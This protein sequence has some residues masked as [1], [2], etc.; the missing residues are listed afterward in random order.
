MKANMKTTEQ[1]VAPG[2]LH[3]CRL[4]RASLIVAVDGPLRIQY[5]DESLTWLT[6]SIVGPVS[7]LLEEGQSHEMPYSAWANIT[8]PGWTSVKTLLMSPPSWVARLI[9]WVGF[10]RLRRPLPPSF[11]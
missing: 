6:T 7:I 4:P 1:H 10:G 9:G 3:M 8:T 2:E 11:S 5:Q